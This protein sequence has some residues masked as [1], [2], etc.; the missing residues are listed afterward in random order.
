MSVTI[1]KENLAFYDYCLCVPPLKTEWG[2]NC[3]CCIFGLLRCGSIP[4]GR[5]FPSYEGGEVI[6][7]QSLEACVLPLPQPDLNGIRGLVCFQKH[8]T[9]FIRFA[10]TTKT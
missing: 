4:V 10:E 6:P 5:T 8:K 9:M 1:Q 7:C 2:G 3:P